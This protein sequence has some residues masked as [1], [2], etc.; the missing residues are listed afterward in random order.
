M[1]RFPLLHVRNDN[2][3]DSTVFEMAQ[4]S[5]DS[6]KRTVASAKSTLDEIDE[7]VLH[8]AKN[9]ADLTDTQALRMEI[10]R[11]SSTPPRHITNAFLKLWEIYSEI[12]PEIVRSVDKEEISTFHLAELPGSF[13]MC[14]ET[15]F[16]TN[17]GM[18]TNWLAQSYCPPTD[19]SG[20]K[21]SSALDDTFGL[22]ENFPARFL[23]SSEY[24]YGDLTDVDAVLQYAR[25]RKTFDLVTGDGAVDSSSDY[26]DQE[27]VCFPL[28]LGQTLAGM[29]MLKQRGIF[30][31]KLFGLFEQ[32][33]RSLL[34]WLS[35]RFERTEIVKPT[36]SRPSNSEYYAVCIGHCQDPLS[37]EQVRTL[38]MR[39]SSFDETRPS[40]DVGKN[41]SDS[42]FVHFLQWQ[43]HRQVASIERLVASSRAICVRGPTSTTATDDTV[44]CRW[45][46]EAF[47]KEWLSRGT[48]HLPVSK[49]GVTTRRHRDS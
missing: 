25:M 2:A 1:I 11:I 21:K 19:A 43:C 47:T 34:Q 31:V 9:A 33:T 29:S 35:E 15:F 37:V 23:N 42:S 24:R 20:G 17:F 39:F 7:R 40:S 18:T 22:M 5:L 36:T 41:V 3:V 26:N 8:R 28:L 16:R 45:L 10:A 38:W 4:S 48:R 14:T 49:T 30:I 32:C 13:V 12:S 46:K 6:M 44:E 27:R